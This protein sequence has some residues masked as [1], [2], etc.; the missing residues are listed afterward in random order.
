MPESTHEPLRDTWVSP[1]RMP[2]A[3][4]CFALAHAQLNGSGRRGAAV[5]T[6]SMRTRTTGLRTVKIGDDFV[7]H[8]R[9]LDEM[10]KEAEHAADREA[11]LNGQY[12]PPAVRTRRRRT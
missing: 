2:G 12:E 11:Q 8:S 5:P 6:C 4:G 1:C 7:D 10:I 9:G 3:S